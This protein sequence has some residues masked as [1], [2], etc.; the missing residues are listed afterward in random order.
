MRVETPPAS[1]FLGSSHR[2]GLFCRRAR[3]LGLVGI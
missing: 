3:D 1:I 2:G